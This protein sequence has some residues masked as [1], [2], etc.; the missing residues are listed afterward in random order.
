MIYPVY[1]EYFYYKTYQYPK[2]CNCELIAL[3]LYF[4]LLLRLISFICAH[5]LKGK[6][7]SKQS[8]YYISFKFLSE[9]LQE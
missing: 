4:L 8:N 9:F 3:L 7:L 2:R 5:L 1:P 6:S